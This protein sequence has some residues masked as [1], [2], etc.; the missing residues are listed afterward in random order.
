MEWD[1][2]KHDKQTCCCV[3]CCAERQAA[4]PRRRGGGI[5][6]V[7]IER[8]YHLRRDEEERRQLPADKVVSKILVTGDRDWDDIT[9][10]VEQL[11]GY[12]P[13]TILVHGA[14]RGADI[15]CAAVAE[16]LGFTVRGY[17]ADWEGHRKAAG[18]IRNQEML[19][20]EHKP[21]EPIDLCL[22]F[23]NDIQNSSGTADMLDR[24]VKAN[25]PWK[26]NTSHPRSSAELERFPAKEEAG[27]SNPPGGTHE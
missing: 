23:H 2:S 12:R 17:P 26:L 25:I 24:V 18:P 20:K 9:L 8:R 15:I 22:A 11:K 5:R 7:K 27:G 1:N 14:C 3:D 19:T 10:V 13:G 21:E 16:A 4:G 6:R